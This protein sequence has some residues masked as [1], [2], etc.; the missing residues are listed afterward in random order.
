MLAAMVTLS[1]PLTKLREIAKAYQEQ[2]EDVSD[3]VSSRRKGF[4]GCHIGFFPLP[5]SSRDPNHQTDRQKAIQKLSEFIT[6]TLKF[7]Y[8]MS[9]SRTEV[10]KL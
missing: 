8:G 5:R 3:L 2:I 1:A 9:D 6:G 10:W 4:G 7:S